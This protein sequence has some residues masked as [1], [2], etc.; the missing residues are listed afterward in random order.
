V[1]SLTWSFEDEEVDAAARAVGEAVADPAVQARIERNVRRPPVLPSRPAFW[2]AHVA[3]LLATRR[4]D[5][6]AV[7]RLLTD[8]AERVGLAAC[9]EVDD[10]AAH[11]RAAVED[12]GAGRG[13]TVGRACAENL[14]RLDGDDGAGWDTLETRLAR[15][16]ACR[17]DEP[18]VE[19]AGTEFEVARF[20]A[21]EVGGEGLYRVGPTAARDLLQLLGLTRYAVPLDATL[22]A[23]VDETF[24]LPPWLAARPV[25]DAFHTH[26]DLLR[27]ACVAADVLPCVLDAAVAGTGWSAA[28]AD[29]VL[30]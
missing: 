27:H 3:A 26:A 13:K 16:V 1:T 22:G 4:S 11:V 29:A 17:R 15:L 14:A 24:D 8:G 20:L 7:A 10:V 12:A 5:G 23:W 6:G 18:T 28:T 19:H 30:D 25:G 9:R 21:A 2:R